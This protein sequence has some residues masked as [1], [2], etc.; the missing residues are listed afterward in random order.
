VQDGSVVARDGTAIT[1]HAHTVGN[2]ARD[3][4]G[5]PIVLTTGL[6]T[7][8][9]FWNPLIAGLVPRHDVVRWDYRG[10]A[11]SEVARSGDYAMAT[12]ADDLLR[13]TEAACATAS[14][15][16]VHVAFSMGVTV[17]LE[18]YRR[19]PDLVRAMVLIAGGADHP[20]ASSP[21]LRLPGARSAIR[22]G[23]RAAA[24]WV[25]RVSPVA[26]AVLT[27]RVPFFLGRA[28][29][30]LAPEAPRVELERFFEAMSTMDYPA[31]WGTLR[32]LFEAH[33]ED[34]LRNV[35][36]PVLIVSAAND[37]LAPKGDLER[38]RQGLPDA[39]WVH[40][41]R[42]GH[43]VLL[44][45]GDLVVRHIQDFLGGLPEPTLRV[46]S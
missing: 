21:V 11:T 5:S 39:R 33:G 12:L 34:V 36:A 40:I 32:A 27:S 23:L 20:Y 44:E 43:A 38:L 10:H 6:G 7:T 16:P 26:R 37:V 4:A 2:E 9:N 45:A 29:G 1:W 14:A 22:A 35:R 18:L 13:V 24:P 8:A 42:T 41:P 31:Y 28:A 3:T 19:R 15:A 25:P 17:L 30:V 46:P